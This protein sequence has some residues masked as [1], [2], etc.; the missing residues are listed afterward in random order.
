MNMFVYLFYVN[1]AS[2]AGYF[3]GK[4]QQQKDSAEFNYNITK[5][6]VVKQQS[7]LWNTML[8]QTK[9]KTVDLKTELVTIYK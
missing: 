5:L 7:E 4:A 3:Y 8:D 1:R 9:M 6:Q 2:T